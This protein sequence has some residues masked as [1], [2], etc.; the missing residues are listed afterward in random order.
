ML[1]LGNTI[2]DSKSFV[3]VQSV[4]WRTNFVIA[5]PPRSPDAMKVA[6]EGSEIYTSLRL[7]NDYF[8]D[9]QYSLFIDRSDGTQFMKTDSSRMAYQSD[10]GGHDQFFRIEMN[11]QPKTHYP[12]SHLHVNG[13]WK[14]GA[15]ARPKDMEKVHFP[16]ARP[17]IESL[18]RL[19]AYDFNVPTHIPPEQFEPI[20]RS[21]E[22]EFLK[23]AR[24]SSKEP[25]P[26]P[27]RED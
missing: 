10:D 17:T 12:F 4:E 7:N 8:L 18:I 24:T 14:P 27:P 19:L 5:P 20:L 23:V 3:S 26:L 11:R 9:L 16:I 6:S 22:Q 1:E 2:L 25:Q 15:K 13:I 21:C